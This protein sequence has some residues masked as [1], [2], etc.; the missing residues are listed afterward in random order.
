MTLKF[1]NDYQT[2]EECRQQ[3]GHY[4]K[5]IEKQ[6]YYIQNLQKL[7]VQVTNEN[8]ALVKRN[9]ELEGHSIS[10]TETSPYSDTMQLVKEL[11]S[12]VNS[13][14]H[15]IS[16]NMSPVPPPRSPYR[17]NGAITAEN[18][19]PQPIV[20][21]PKRPPALK[22]T[23]SNHSPLHLRSAQ[24]TDNMTR[25]YLTS[26]RRHAHHPSSPTFHSPATSPSSGFSRRTYESDNIVSPKTS[27]S[28]RKF[29]HHSSSG[30]SS[31]IRDK[32][33]T[34]DY[35]ESVISLDDNRSISP[36]PVDLDTDRDFENF[37]LIDAYVRNLDISEK[38]HRKSFSEPNTPM[39]ARIPRYDS[40]A[41]NNSNGNVSPLDSA[42]ERMKILNNLAN[43]SINVTQPT[44]KSKMSPT[45]AITVCRQVR[46]EDDYPL[47]E[48][49][50]QLSDFAHLDLNLKKNSAIASKLNKL[51]D[52]SIFSSRAFSKSEDQ[53]A[54]IQEYLH[55]AIGLRL[56]DSSSLCNFLCS[57]SI[58]NVDGRHINRDLVQGYLA[59]RRRNFGGRKKKYFVL[60]NEFMKYYESKE[61]TFLG[62]I[63]LSNS[64]ISEHTSID[65]ET[66][67]GG[68]YGFV[69][70]EQRKSASSRLYRHTLFADSISEREMW[71][72]ALRNSTD[73][74]FMEDNNKHM[75]P[76]PKI[77][78]SIDNLIL[79]PSSSTESIRVATVRKRPSIDHIYS[80]FHGSGSRR[81]SSTNNIMRESISAPHT[82]DFMNLTNDNED[83]DSRNHKARSPRRAFW[84][85][86]KNNNN[87]L[88]P[89][90]SPSS[91]ILSI[92]ADGVH[93]YSEEEDGSGHRKTFGLPLDNIVSISKIYNNYQLPS[94][95]H[96]CIEYLEERNGLLEEGIY[97]MSGSSQKLL[98]LRKR[99]NEEGDID[100]LVDNE[101]HDVHTIAGLLKMWLRE[102]PESILTE[103]LLKD[104][105]QSLKLNEKEEKTNELSRLI[106]QLPL[107]NY[108]LLRTLCSHLIRVIQNAEKNR[109]TLRNIV[110]VFS[111]TLGIPSGV[112]SLFL[113]DFECI[114]STMRYQDRITPRHRYSKIPLPLNPTDE[115]TASI[116]IQ[117]KI[118]DYESSNRNSF[119]Y[120][121]HAPKNTIDLENL[122][123]NNPLLFD[124][125]DLVYEDESYFSEGELGVAYLAHRQNANANTTVH[126]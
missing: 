119:H 15:S 42:I 76:E 99:F 57:E 2:M 13:F 116:P 118:E 77:L 27:T 67:T 46:S 10:S 85:K 18:N 82:P 79:E 59:K 100:L 32:Q 11:L 7:M 40:L 91:S 89:P 60:E 114:F 81:R 101:D 61:G 3:N 122:L 35:S 6:R 97:R 92:S 109:M 1:S 64:Q 68:G 29:I 38:S 102:L 63:R 124:D 94:I 62:M 25:E 88:L 12:Q 19:M 106:S 21:L 28:P 65:H 58:E 16:P 66:E 23:M 30:S 69:I 56:I 87:E 48:I 84:G 20:D 24:E 55:H 71:I 112:F 86:K 50:K 113:T 43:I 75:L 44:H 22:L 108:T 45:F 110:I 73:A 9:R 37:S 107:I 34:Q 115:C 105:L 98:L 54:A 117:I 104:F 47:W 41:Q 126:S 74:I 125:E 111:A 78:D 123:E 103:I 8:E 14:E 52:S 31:S 121:D 120:Q 90:T 80:Y 5:I 33:Q 70:L 83:P 26:P 17:V 93:P 49:S 96:R 51:T 4:W 39:K 95:A 36:P 72:N 53:V